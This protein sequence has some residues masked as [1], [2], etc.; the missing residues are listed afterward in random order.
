[1]TELLE[2]SGFRNVAP[3]RFF[4]SFAGTTKERVAGQY[5]VQG[6]NFLAYK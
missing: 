1:M 3:R 2:K 4:D 6:A 5:Q